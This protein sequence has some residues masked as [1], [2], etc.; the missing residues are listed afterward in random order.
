MHNNHGSSLDKASLYQAVE[1][2][3]FHGANTKDLIRGCYTSINDESYALFGGTPNSV[4]QPNLWCDET[5]AQ[6]RIL[7]DVFGPQAADFEKYYLTKKRGSRNWL[8]GFR[9]LL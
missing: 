5:N 2:L 9:K 8:A 6:L 7:K 1:L 4:I 3:L